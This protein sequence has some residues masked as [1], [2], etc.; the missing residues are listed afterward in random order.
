MRSKD[1]LWGQNYHWCNY[2][3]TDSI[4]Y[5]EIAMSSWNIDLDKKTATSINGITFKL[6][7]VEPD[8]FQWICTNPKDIPPD[9]LDD[10]IL[11]KMVKEADAMNQWQLK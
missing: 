8:V 11:S 10:E 5:V 4:S 1:E 2:R 7:E 6:T 9:D 3:L